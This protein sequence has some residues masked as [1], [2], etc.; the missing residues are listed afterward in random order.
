[1]RSIPL[2]YYIFSL[3]EEI[4]NLGYPNGIREVVSTQQGNDIYQEFYKWRQDA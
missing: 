4:F 1:M 2:S 3:P